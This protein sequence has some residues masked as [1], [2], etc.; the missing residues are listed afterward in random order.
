M[1]LG[2]GMGWDGYGD[3]M[4]REAEWGYMDG[5]ISWI[6]LVFR[7]SFVSRVRDVPCD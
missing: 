3:S 6:T 1:G 5:W 2:L 7:V 4:S